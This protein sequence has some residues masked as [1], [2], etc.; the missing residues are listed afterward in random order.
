[1]RK[2]YESYMKIYINNI[3]F[4]NSYQKK[5]NFLMNK[6]FSYDECFDIHHFNKYLDIIYLMDL[7]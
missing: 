7:L 6:D 2:Y 1:M 3:R 4:N 5:N